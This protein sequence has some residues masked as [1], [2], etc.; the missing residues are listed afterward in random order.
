MLTLCTPFYAR[1]IIFGDFRA[2]EDVFFCTVRHPMVQHLLHML[3]L[4]E[5][6][7]NNKIG[8][9]SY[10]DDTQ[11]YITICLVTVRRQLE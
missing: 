5:S 8:C 10:A 11:I 9:H 3:P 2:N 4:V 6:T 7:Q 1:M